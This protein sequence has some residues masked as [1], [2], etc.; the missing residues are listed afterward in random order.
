MYGGSV[1]LSQSEIDSKIIQIFNETGKTFESLYN[2]VYEAISNYERF[3]VF[4]ADYQFDKD[5]EGNDIL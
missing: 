1:G 5:E 2:I 3:D 4:K